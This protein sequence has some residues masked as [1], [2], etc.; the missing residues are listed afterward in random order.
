MYTT[1]KI[2][3]YQSGNICS[4]AK[5]AFLLPK[6]FGRIIEIFQ[7]E[8][9]GRY[10]ITQILKESFRTE[11]EKIDKFLKLE[12]GF[13]FVISRG[14]ESLGPPKFLEP[15]K[16]FDPNIVLLIQYRTVQLY[17]PLEHKNLSIV[18]N[19]WSA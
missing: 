5:Y 13:P 14:P 9:C 3:T 4:G 12:P 16:L 1:L 17:T 15:P 10:L 11:N 19:L 2:F 18:P 6:S 7:F 8:I